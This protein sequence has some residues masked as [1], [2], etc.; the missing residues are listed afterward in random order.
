MKCQKPMS[1]F[2]VGLLSVSCV[3]FAAR[4][5][6]AEPVADPGSRGVDWPKVKSRAESQPW[7]RS[8][9]A[10]MK[11]AVATAQK[12]YAEPP[13]GESGWFHDYYCPKDARRLVF[14][15]QKPTEHRCEGCGTVYSGSPYDDVWRSAVHGEIISAIHSAAI[16][17]RI[18]GDAAYLEYTSGKLL[19]YANHYDQ[20]PPHGKHAGKGRIGAQSLDEATQTVDLAE[21]YWD[22]CPALSEGDRATIADKLLIP[23]AK[24]I[25]SQTLAIHNIHSWHNAAVGLVGFAVGDKD[26]ARVAID[27]PFGLNAQIAQGIKDDGF[28]YEGSTGYHFYTI[29]SM[30][31]LLLAAR[32]QGYPIANLERFLRMYEVP[33]AMAFDDGQFPGNNDGWSGMNLL[34]TPQYY[35]AATAIEPR[36]EFLAMLARA[37]KERPRNSTDAL[38]YGPD[39]IPSAEAAA[40]KSN[41]L[42][43]S[44]IAI[45]RKD[46]VNAYLKFGPYGGGHDHNDRLN[47]I[48][49]HDGHVIVPDLGTSGYGI[50]LNSQWF[51]SAAAHNLLIVDGKKQANCGG[52]LGDFSA[53]R[54]SAGVSKAFNGV[55]I[56]RQISLIE[57]GI[58]DQVAAKSDNEHTYDL[59]YHVRGTLQSCTV[60]MQP[61]EPLKGDGYPML[62]NLQKGNADKVCD[63]SLK[64]RDTSGRL[65]LRLESSGAFE[66]FTG[67][68]PDNPA[69]KTMVFV[70][71]RSTGKEA[72]WKNQ[73]VVQP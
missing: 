26:L 41:L 9:V 39:A 49:Y 30:K 24:F 53:D 68:C 32:A 13:L 3:L 15:W 59:I 11:S 2:V 73:I 72:E 4:S 31:P 63:V 36:P 19:W 17:Y 20:Y 29:S 70:I 55:T 18:T 47:L 60:A 34:S 61:T 35:E 25:H 28:W 42:K 37:Y 43:E 71:V 58:D 38:L 48:L 64:L 67:T 5:A 51:R 7:A 54:V 6:A 56:Q 14:D 65:T 57:N 62:K 52:E 33:L 21:A 22:I 40:P 46:K 8:I 50:P 12:R 45:L 66:V 16:L 44:G 69:D 27:G 10:A 1:G 23:A